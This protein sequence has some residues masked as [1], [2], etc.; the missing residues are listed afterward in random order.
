MTGTARRAAG[1][2]RE[3][4]GLDVLVIPTNKPCIRIDHDDIIFADKDSKYK[5]LI[6]EISRVHKTGRPILVGTASVEESEMLSDML[7]KAGVRN[8]VLNAKNDELEA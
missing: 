4:Y 6:E 7:H 8:N 5:A 1:E 3:F 2:I